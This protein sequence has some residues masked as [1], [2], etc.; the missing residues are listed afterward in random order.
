MQEILRPFESACIIVVDEN[1]DEVEVNAP[2]RLRE[3]PFDPGYAEHTV[4]NP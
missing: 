2:P 3:R 4:R 1:L